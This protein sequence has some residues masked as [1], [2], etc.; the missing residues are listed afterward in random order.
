MDIIII[1]FPII[2]LEKVPVTHVQLCH[3]LD[4]EDQLLSIVLSHCQYSLKYGHGQDISYDLP[5]LQKHIVDRFIHGKP[6]LIM[7]FPQVIYREDVY[8]AASFANI[9]KN[10]SPQVH[11]H[12]GSVYVMCVC[13]MCVCV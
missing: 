7:D 2:R 3:L 9:R 10:V 11:V 12:V 4:Y 1:C 8:T 5:A 13:N 6:Q